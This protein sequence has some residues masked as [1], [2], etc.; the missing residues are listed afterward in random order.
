[1]PNPSSLRNEP[2]K[3]VLE[4]LH[5]AA[6]GDRF[7][8]L[9]LAPRLALGFLARRNLWREVLTPEAMKELYIPV[10]PEQGQ[11]LYLTARAIGARRI[12]E[13]GTS[14]G[15]ST[16]YLAAAV[17]DN[18]GGLVVGSEI[19]PGKH[20]RAVA[21]L[22]EAGL[23]EVTDVRLG[24]A[25][26]TLRELPEPIDLVLLDGWKDLYLPVLELVTPRLRPG[27]VVLA[28]NIFTFRKSLRPYVNHMQSGE[29]GFVSTTLHLADGFEYSVYLGKG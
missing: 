20:A 24:D 6:R 16:L 27:A 14:F 12:V 3:G 18:G 22:E 25:L 26:E 9:K 11:L 5:A 8:G 28:D 2:L 17:H 21:H 23:T 7:R 19:E 4:R 10:S 1:M 15:I 13:F 29:H